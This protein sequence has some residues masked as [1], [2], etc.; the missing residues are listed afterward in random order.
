MFIE[1]EAA[2]ELFDQLMDAVQPLEEHWTPLI[3]IITG[4][5][6]PISKLVAKQQPLPLQQHPKALREEDQCRST[7]IMLSTQ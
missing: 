6:T 1:L 2:R 4:V 5:A 7:I 3:A